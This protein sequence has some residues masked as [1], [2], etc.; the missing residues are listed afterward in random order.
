LALPVLSVS[1]GELRQVAGMAGERLMSWFKV[2]DKLHD[3]RKVAIAGA[4]AMGLWVIA[5]SWCAGNPETDGFISLRV[6]ARF[7]RSW[8]AKAVKLVEASLW[9]PSKFKGEDGYQFMHWAEY[10]FTAADKE[11]DR[12]GARERMRALR[13]ERKGRSEDVRPNNPDVRKSSPNVPDPVPVPVPIPE[14]VPKEQDTAALDCFNEFWFVYPRKDDKPKAQ[15]AWKKAIKA[16]DVAAIVAGAR[17]YASDPNRKP[18]FTKL[19]ATWLNSESWNN[20]PQP[21]ER[22]SPRST[23][24]DRMQSTLA[25]ISEIDREPNGQRQ[26][27]YR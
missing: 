25:L 18:S 2:D 14:P 10:Q 22:A 23:T 5:G 7:S 15:A 11:K 9:E 21:A 1:A 19:P 12:D 27:G 20:A 16:H 26:I 4:D 24:E 6:V 13:A 8:R 17:R 3:H